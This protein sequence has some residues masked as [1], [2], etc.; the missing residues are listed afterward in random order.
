M[1]MPIRHML[2]QARAGGYGFLRATVTNLEE[3]EAVLAAAEETQSPIGFSVVENELRSPRYRSFG[4][5]AIGTAMKSPLPV[6]V[7]LD[8]TEDMTLILRAL[9]GGYNGIMVDAACHPFEENVA[10]TK[11]VVELCRPLNVLVEGEVGLIH[12]TWDEGPADGEHELTDPDAAGEYVD[13][14][15]IDALAVSIGEVSGFHSGDLDLERLK[16]IHAIVGDKAHLCLH[17]VSFIPDENIRACMDNGMT[18]F[19][20]ATEFRQAFFQKFDEVRDTEGAKM[21]DPARMYE[22]ARAAM[23]EKV[24]AKIR[25]LGSQGKAG[26][27]IAS[28]FSGGSR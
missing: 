24:A 23:T 8:H 7:Q 21:T 27:V 20:C 15:G 22:P 28:Y 6:G 13:Q 10:T 26:E 2:D 17:G 16:K 12:K 3:I 25:L 1:L 4:S 19:G 11:K 14:T 5:C 9:K 18:Y